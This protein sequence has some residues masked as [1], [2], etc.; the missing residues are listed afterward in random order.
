MNH[1]K[2]PTAANF[3]LIA[4]KFHFFVAISVIDCYKL[5]NPYFVPCKFNRTWYVVFQGKV[6]T[7]SAAFIQDLKQKIFLRY[8]RIICLE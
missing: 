3:H 6:R 7:G 1:T 2:L 8:M 5:P 4:T